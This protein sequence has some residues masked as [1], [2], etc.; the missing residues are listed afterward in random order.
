ME[1]YGF[2]KDEPFNLQGE[3]TMEGKLFLVDKG[4]VVVRN[5]SGTTVSFDSFSDFYDF[6]SG[7]IDLSEEY[8]IDYEPQNKLFYYKNDPKNLAPLSNRYDTTPHIQ[9]YEDVIADVEKMKKKMMDPYFRMSETEARAY[10]LE[11]TNASTFQTIDIHLPQWKQAKWNN[12]IRIYE[13]KESGETLTSLEQTIYDTSLK[14]GQTHLSRYEGA[15]EAMKWL[16]KCTAVNNRQKAK[17]R[18]AKS[19]KEIKSIPEASYP[20]WPL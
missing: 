8:Y 10:K 9:A 2:A 5:S 3:I 11:T 12:F 15:I 19:V 1:A 7:N 16:I 20:E 4:N 14:D 18:K 6:Y 17:L 13:K